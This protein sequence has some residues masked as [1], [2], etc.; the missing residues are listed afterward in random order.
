MK[1]CLLALTLLLS[2]PPNGV[3]T[4]PDQLIPAAQRKPAA[5]FTLPDNY[6][7]PLTLSAYKGKVVLLDF[8]AT[9]CGGCK[10]ELPW[11]IQFDRQY[12]DHGLAVVGVSMDDDGM[13]VVKPFLARKHILYPVVIGSETLGKSFGLG[14]MPLTLLIDRQGRIALAHPGV[15]DRTDF[16]RHI[17]QLLR[18]P[19][20]RTALS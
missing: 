2:P 13:K 5:D 6:G 1:L 18:E 8:W 15:V 20:R 7:R 10:L 11:Y 4:T 16:E 19:G 12:R 3:R 14:Q 9:W 17:Q